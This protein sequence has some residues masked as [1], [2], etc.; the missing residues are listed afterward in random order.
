MSAH[1]ES[2]TTAPTSESVRVAVLGAGM[3]G[4]CMGIQLRKHGIDDFV[5]LEKAD[6]VG[7]TWRENTYPGVACDVPSHVYSF[8]FE[9]NPNWSHSYSSGR[10]IWDYC[11]RCV[12]KYELA[13]QDPLRHARNERRRSTA[14]AGTSRP[15]AVVRSRR[16]SSSADSAD[17]TCRTARRSTASS[18]SPARVF[19]PRSG[20]TPQNLKGRRVAIIG[21]G[22][23]AAQ[24][25]PEIAKDVADVTVFQRSAAWVFPRLAHDIPE[26]R[27]ALFGRMPWLM[28][29][30]R[31]F[32]WLMMDVIGTLVAAPQ[33]LVRGTAAQGRP[34]APRRIRQRSRSCARA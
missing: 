33:Q 22:A 11:E 25:L 30:Y 27:R 34:R 28:R 10:E 7:G 3:S 13:R 31:W 9:L 6:S 20:I 5:I 29:L 8:S 16:M 17:C 18:R 21:T 32:L 24:V 15:R 4:I 1:P 14:P 12:D 19:T 26:Q 2:I 23:S